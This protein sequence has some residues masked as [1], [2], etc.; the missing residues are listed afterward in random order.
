MERECTGYLRGM[1]LKESGEF[2]GNVA[3]S[4]VDRANSNAELACWC[5][6]EHQGRG[7]ASEGAKR[8]VDWGFEELGLE[9][10]H[11]AC[12]AENVAGARV[13]EN[14]G[15]MLEGTARHGRRRGGEFLDV[16]HYAIVKADW[17]ETRKAE[18]VLLETD[19]LLL[20]PPLR[21][22]ALDVKRAF[23]HPDFAGH[24]LHFPNP[25]TVR[26]AKDFI[27]KSR[28]LR[29][30][31]KAY[32]FA[33]VLKKTGRL[34]GEVHL[35]WIYWPQGYSEIG[36]SLSPDHWRKG[37]ASEGTAE[38]LRH[39]FEDLGLR[40]IVGLTPA[41]NTAARRLMQKLGMDLECIA[42]QEWEFGGSY[43]DFAHYVIL[44]S[45]WEKKPSSK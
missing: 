22:D 3:L 4:S 27:R 7:Y 20:R 28:N 15:L 44:R 33:V 37:I 38:L 18:A 19:R 9:R 40:R 17:E 2:A 45:D 36:F 10:I 5:D 32:Y 39:A 21:D 29:R 1:Y 12:D 8:V 14:A 42:R 43:V 30:E 35:A 25:Y 13:A 31:K 6:K 41:D 24:A 11:A 16:H 26:D 23:D 34:I